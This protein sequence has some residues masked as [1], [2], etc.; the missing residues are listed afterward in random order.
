MFCGGTI[1]QRELE[2]PRSPETGMGSNNWLAESACNPRF[3]KD[4]PYHFG[5]RNI[6]TFPPFLHKNNQIDGETHG[7]IRLVPDGS[8]AFDDFQGENMPMH[9]EGIGFLK[10]SVHSLLKCY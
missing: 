9:E 1:L 4:A 6:Q 10:F 7:S 2:L 3:K 8:A 5:A